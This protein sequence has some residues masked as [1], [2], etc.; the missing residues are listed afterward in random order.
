M[1][2][3]ESTDFSAY[4]DHPERK[5]IEVVSRHGVE[6]SLQTD[7]IDKSRGVVPELVT[8]NPLLRNKVNNKITEGRYVHYIYSDGF[9]G[10]A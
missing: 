3:R 2:F 1:A 9:H 4:G 7:E 5:K 10:M 6:T 8:I